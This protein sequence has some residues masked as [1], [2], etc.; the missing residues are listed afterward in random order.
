MDSHTNLDLRDRRRRLGC[1][2][3]DV[4]LRLSV[5]VGSLSR[6]ERGF[7]ALPRGLTREH[8]EQALDEL[9]ETKRVAS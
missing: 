4:A 7:R 3:D 6:F 5:D 9:A 2:L 1:S 8:Y